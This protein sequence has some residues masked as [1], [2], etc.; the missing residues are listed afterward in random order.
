MMSVVKPGKTPQIIDT[1]Q[2]DSAIM[3]T[4]AAVDHELYVRTE[5]SIY[6]IEK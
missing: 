6:R 1:N 4:P 3:A 2:L 5:K